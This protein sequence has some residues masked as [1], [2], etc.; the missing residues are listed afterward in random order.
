M[1][2]DSNPPPDFPRPSPPPRPPV[3]KNEYILNSN[4]G[5]A[6]KAVVELGRKWGY[7]N[8]IDRLKMAWALSLYEQ[9]LSLESVAIA[10]G[11]D[12]QRLAGGNEAAIIAEMRLYVGR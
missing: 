3:K 11:F 10:A 8:M 2:K 4:E 7:G 12:P 9:G 1:K 6:I 5:F